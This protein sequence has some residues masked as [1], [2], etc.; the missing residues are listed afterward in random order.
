MVEL[1]AHNVATGIM[2]DERL[3]VITGRRLAK[4]HRESGGLSF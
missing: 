3:A 2:V 1:R 4:Q